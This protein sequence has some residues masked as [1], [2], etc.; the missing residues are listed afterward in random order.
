MGGQLEYFGMWLDS[1]YGKGHSKGKPTC[2]TF[3]SPQLSASEQFEIDELEAWGIGPEPCD[4]SGDDSVTTQA[5]TCSTLF[6][7]SYYCV[8]IMKQYAFGISIFVGY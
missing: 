6:I 5:S 1:E 2:T 3:S 7:L 4:D 8:H